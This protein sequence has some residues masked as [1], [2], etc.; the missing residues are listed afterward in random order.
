MG[1]FDTPE[2]AELASMLRTQKYNTL[3]DPVRTSPILQF[4]K[5]GAV[6]DP[7]KPWT[8]GQPIPGTTKQK[9]SPELQ[10]F[11][12]A[13]KTKL[14]NQQKLKTAEEQLSR[15][16][17][18]RESLYRR[19]IGTLPSQNNMLLNALDVATDVGQLGSFVPTPFTQYIGIG[20]SIIG[21]GVDAYQALEDVSED[22]YAGAFANMA[23]ATVPVVL[24]KWGY[25][26][27]MNFINNYNG[28]Y[29]PLNYLPGATQGQ[30][31]ALRPFINVNRGI[32][33][34]LGAEAGYDI[35]KKGGM[36]KR[37]DGSYSKRG[38]WDNIRANRGSGK[39]PTKQMLEQ[40]RKI[41]AKK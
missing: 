13:E 7:V 16:S 14:A 29:R 20:S 3:I 21:A 5:G 28:T 10:K 26:R 24:S 32:L 23:S 1:M 11:L 39:K 12:A 35:Y 40:E 41:K 34:T 17:E 30:R 25:K 6:E 2:Q 27:P 22:N 36:I 8:V 31:D 18:M 19:P 9:I 38:L 33:G 15:E 37:A 4:K